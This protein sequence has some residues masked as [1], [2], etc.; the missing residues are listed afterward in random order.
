MSTSSIKI[1]GHPV[2]P[3]TNIATSVAKY[4]EIPSEFV[5]V[6]ILKGEQKAESYVSKN[7]H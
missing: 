6:D 5:L 2:S 3:P 7:P 4:L 1:Y